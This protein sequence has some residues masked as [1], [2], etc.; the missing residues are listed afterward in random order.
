MPSTRNEEYRYTDISPLLNAALVMGD[1]DGAVDAQ[2][3]EQL[4]VPEAAGSR[5]VLVNGAFRPELSDL[6]A[7]GEGVYVGSAAGAPA[8]VLEQLVSSGARCLGG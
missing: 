8:E 7:L 1:A 3:L 4:A 2:Q 5:V 6:T